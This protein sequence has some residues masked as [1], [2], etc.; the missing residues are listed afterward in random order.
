ML[1]LLLFKVK[2]TSKVSALFFLETLTSTPEVITVSSISSSIFLILKLPKT[3]SLENACVGISF[4]S[5]QLKKKY[6]SAK[7]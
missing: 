4:F 1:V 3:I 7:K 5:I 2:L 6:Y